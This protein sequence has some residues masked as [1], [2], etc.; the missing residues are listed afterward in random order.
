MIIVAGRIY[1]R[2]GTRAAFL[3]RSSEA[4]VQARRSAGCR[5]VV[6]A[7]DPIAADRVNVYEEWES[8]EVLLA[9]RGDGPDQA[10]VSSIVR[11]QVS[12]HRVSSSEPV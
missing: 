5:D 9:F 4:V 8:E 3:T 7:A 11:A 12:Q 10:L 6:V 1:V 2:P